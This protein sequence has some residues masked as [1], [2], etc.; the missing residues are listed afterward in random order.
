M[1]RTT[2]IVYIP[3][4]EAKFT[5]KNLDIS[6]CIFASVGIPNVTSM[7]KVASYTGGY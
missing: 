7:H 5:G 2:V 1:S 6:P 4:L 3:L